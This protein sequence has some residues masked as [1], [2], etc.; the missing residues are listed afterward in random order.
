MQPTHQPRFSQLRW[1]WLLLTWCCIALALL[2]VML[3][4]L[5]TTVFVLIAAWSAS[6]CSPR[7]HQWLRQHRLLGP[8]LH[9]WEQGGYI[10]RRTKWLASF[11]MMTAL[12]I[13][14]V[15]IEQPLLI[16]IIMLLIAFGAGVVWTRPEPCPKISRQK[17]PRNSA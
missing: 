1:F 14:L 2:G 13:V 5:P 4:G 9:H 3:P 11:G 8:S 12:I 17:L 16:T 7:L 6:R 10:D 15:S